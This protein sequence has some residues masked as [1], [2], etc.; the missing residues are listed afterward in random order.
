MKIACAKIQFGI[1]FY[2]ATVLKVI[3]TLPQRALRIAAGEP[4]GGERG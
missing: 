4:R 3:F 2:V 1:F